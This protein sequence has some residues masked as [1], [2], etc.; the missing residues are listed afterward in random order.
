MD[1]KVKYRSLNYAVL[2]NELFKKTLEGVLLKCLGEGE[3][4][5]AVSSVH[6]EA[7]GDH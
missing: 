3:A 5:L 2:G 1:R 7:C 4:Y 6:N